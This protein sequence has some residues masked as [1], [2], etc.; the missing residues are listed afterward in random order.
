M[1]S[2]TFKFTCVSTSLDVET[3]LAKCVRFPF[4]RRSKFEVQK[5]EK[6]ENI[7]VL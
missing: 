5:K 1:L 2:V 7:G 3:N 6:H 4:R